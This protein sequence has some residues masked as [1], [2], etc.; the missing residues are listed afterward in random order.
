MI[1]ISGSEDERRAAEALEI[2][3]ILVSRMPDP[4]SSPITAEGIIHKRH[5]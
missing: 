4:F 3:G 2:I 1:Q 5:P